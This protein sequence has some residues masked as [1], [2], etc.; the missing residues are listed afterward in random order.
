M[1]NKT[2]V[3]QISAQGRKTS[4]EDIKEAFKEAAPQNSST[5]QEATTEELESNA[6]QQSTIFNL[7]TDSKEITGNGDIRLDTFVEKNIEAMRAEHPVSKAELSA[8][9]AGLKIA[10]D[11]EGFEKRDQDVASYGYQLTG[12]GMMADNAPR[13]TVPGMSQQEIEKLGKQSDGYLSAGEV[14][15]VKKLMEAFGTKIYNTN[16]SAFPSAGKSQAST[17]T[18]VQ[19]PETGNTVNGPGQ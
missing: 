3:A 1:G 8:K 10:P 4:A 18:I 9:D 13:M 15:N 11:S 17:G 6:T 2:E 12:A 19:T 16:D 7:P 5:E 14:E